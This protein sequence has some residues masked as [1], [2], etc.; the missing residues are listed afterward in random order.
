MLAASFCRALVTPFFST[1]L[2]QHVEFMSLRF[3]QY[4]NTPSTGALPEVPYLVPD[5]AFVICYRV[6]KQCLIPPANLG[7]R[8]DSSQWQALV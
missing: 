5:S 7:F 3:R 6:A 8:R 1:L 2:C 4:G